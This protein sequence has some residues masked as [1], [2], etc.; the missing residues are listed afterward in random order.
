METLYQDLRYALRMLIKSPAFTSVAILTLALGIGANTAIFTLVNALLLK[1]LPVKAP[2]ELVAI[3]DPSVVNN[4]SS[5]TPSVKN[6]SVPLYRELRDHN[7][8]FSGLIAGAAE[9]RI[10]VNSGPAGSGS[11]ENIVGRLVSGNYF[12]VL[13][14]EPAAGRLLAENDD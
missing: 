14:V 8:V 3:G 7:A 9:H 12:S 11:Q 6:F 10:E 13:G 1:M 4:R 2:Q 5:G